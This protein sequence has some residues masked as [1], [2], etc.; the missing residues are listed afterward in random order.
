[1]MLVI[2]LIFNMQMGFMLLEVSVSRKKHSRNV[3]LKNLL[4][5][6]VCSLGFWLVGYNLSI[7]ADGGVIGKGI[8]SSNN[9]NYYIKWLIAFCFCNTSSTIVSGCIAERMFND[10]YICF[11]LLMVTLIYPVTCSWSWGGGWLQ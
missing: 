2:S 10:T 3:L 8:D 7:G 6:F 11:S 4:D 9:E 1:M 5:T